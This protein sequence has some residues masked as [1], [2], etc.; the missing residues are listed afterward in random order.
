MTLTVINGGHHSGSFRHKNPLSFTLE[1]GCLNLVSS[2]RCRVP[3]KNYEYFGLIGSSWQL[4]PK[5]F[6]IVLFVVAFWFLQQLSS[7]EGQNFP[8]APSGFRHSLQ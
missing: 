2:W 4:I 1:S 8:S 7:T 5:G 3:D 6:S